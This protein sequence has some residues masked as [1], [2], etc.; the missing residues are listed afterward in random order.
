MKTAHTHK[1]IR[2]IAGNWSTT[3]I[4]NDYTTGSDHFTITYEGKSVYY[5]NDDVL[6]VASCACQ[7]NG[8]SSAEYFRFFNSKCN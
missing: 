8:M 1:E 7:Y 2:E 4:H 3:S 6:N 5:Q